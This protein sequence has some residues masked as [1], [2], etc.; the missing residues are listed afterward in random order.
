MNLR[1]AGQDRA[2]DN[3]VFFQIGQEKV[4]LAKTDPGALHHSLGHW[5]YQ[6]W[7]WGLWHRERPHLHFT[8]LKLRLQI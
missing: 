4:G 5:W 1:C 2:E 3:R 8:K 6:R 7:L